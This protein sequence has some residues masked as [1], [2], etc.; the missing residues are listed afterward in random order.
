MK[1]IRLAVI[2]GAVGVAIIVSVT[3][4]SKEPTAPAKPVNANAQAMPDIEPPKPSIG[5]PAVEPP[6]PSVGVPTVVPPEIPK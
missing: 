1:N 4:C 6:K 5:A 3:G 2:T